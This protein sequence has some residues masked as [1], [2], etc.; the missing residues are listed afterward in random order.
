MCHIIQQVDDVVH[1]SIPIYFNL[2]HSKIYA[3]SLE[4]QGLPN[5]SLCAYP[6]DERARRLQ[7]RNSHIHSGCKETFSPS[8]NIGIAVKRDKFD[9]RS[10]SMGAQVHFPRRNNLRLD[11]KRINRCGPQEK[12]RRSDKTSHLRIDSWLEQ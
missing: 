8:A 7:K 3:C 1:A 12:S 4:N 6:N 2:N 11:R 10:R 5:V 9:Y